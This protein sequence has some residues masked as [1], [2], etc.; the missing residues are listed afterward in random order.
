MVK[1]GERTAVTYYFSTSGGQTE[2]VEF[3][4]PGAEP[5]S[6]LKG[7]RDP[8]DDASPYHR[9]KLK[10]SRSQIESRLG[11]LVEGSLREID[12]IKTGASP[13]I[14][15]ARIEGSRGGEK[16]SGPTLQGALG[17]RSTWARFKK[18]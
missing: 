14:V 3:G 8:Y 6:Y 13:R 12:V 11:G 17:L 2:N 16:M 4:F 1:D 5:R 7:V 9:W 10:L 15:K 18:R